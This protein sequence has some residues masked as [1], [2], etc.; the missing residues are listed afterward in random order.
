MTDGG[1]DGVRSYQRIFSPER[2]IHQVEGRP[3][4]VPGGIPLRWLGWFAGSLVAV[5][6]L[7]SGSFI[8]PVVAAA[9]A[10]AGGLAIAD[11]TAGLLAAAAAATGTMVAGVVLGAL[12]WPIR[13]VVV[14]IAI[15]TVATQATPDGRRPERF[16][17]SWLG[18]RLAPPRRSL[19][20]GLPP[21]GTRRALDTRLWIAHD[22]SG[23]R[24]RHARLTGPGA[25]H[26][27]SPVIV[28][29]R[30]GGAL[31]VREPGRLSR[32][33]RLRHRVALRPGQTLEVRP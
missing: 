9:A 16:A 30:L 24:L 19:G 12:D 28:R 2:R 31:V 22:A 3:L 32:R 17:I 26:F 14:P 20:R 29:R 10:G 25:V 15:A 7:G 23:L 21:V 8:V 5:L 1:T 18:L 6:A 27:T 13:L 33:G 4:P 11:R